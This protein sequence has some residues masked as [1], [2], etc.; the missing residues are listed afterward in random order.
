M[1]KRERVEELE[2]KSII[3]G[4]MILLFIFSL[5]Y[6]ALSMQQ[7]RRYLRDAQRNWLTLCLS[8]QLN[9]I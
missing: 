2:M 6:S 8:W 4:F 5:V 1:V 9:W 3:L 7:M